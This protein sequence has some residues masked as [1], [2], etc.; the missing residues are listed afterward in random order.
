[1]LT[2]ITSDTLS[3]LRFIT[4]QLNQEQF[5][6]KL[7]LLNGSSIG[8]HI[9]HILEFYICLSQGVKSG[10]VDYDKRVRNQVIETDPV[11]AVKIMDELHSVFCLGESEDVTLSHIF[12]YHN[13]IIEAHSSLCRELIYLTEHSIHHSAIIAIALRSHFHHVELPDNFGVAYS[14]TKHHQRTE[15]ESVHQH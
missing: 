12:E 11:Y 15:T 1:M 3:Q 5:S 8:Q 13:H 7:P 6:Q 2:K 4:N 10:K 14:T 9:R